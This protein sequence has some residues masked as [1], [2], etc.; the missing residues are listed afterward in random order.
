MWMKGREIKAAFQVIGK[1]SNLK[2]ELCLI[3]RKFIYLRQ[4]KSILLRFI[5]LMVH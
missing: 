4:R 5:R 1:N 2:E 3:Y